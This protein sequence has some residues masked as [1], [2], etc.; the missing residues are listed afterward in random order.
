MAT[1]IASFS[2]SLDGFVAR[3]TDDVGPLFDWYDNGKVETRWPGMGMVSHTSPSSARVLQETIAGGGAL[4]VGRRL[5]DYTKGWGGNHPMNVPVFVV[6]HGNIPQQWIA[7]H[8]GAP[9][10]FVTDGV[11]SAI[12]QAMVVA[13]EKTVGVAGPNIA[14][15][16]LNASLLD[17][18]HVDLVPVL[19]GTGIPFFQKLSETPVMLEDPTIIAG[20]R[21]THLRFRVRRAGA[22]HDR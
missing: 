7:E 12:R 4:V 15:Q 5:F 6:T 11:E 20:T 13:G 22:P 10:T 9:F 8:P 21:V 3:P 18:I 16:L 14:Q 1:V 2:M 17:E 19:L